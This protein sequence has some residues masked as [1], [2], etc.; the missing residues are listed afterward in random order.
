MFRQ[1]LF[2]GVGVLALLGVPGSPGQLHA[3]GSR[4]GS[5]H[6]SHMG[7]RQG[8]SPRF[9]NMAMPGIGFDPRFNGR[10]FDLR[11]SPPALSVIF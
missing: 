11:F 8:F 4:N 6:G 3:Q 9:G 2:L 10:F 5:H 7:F 1:C